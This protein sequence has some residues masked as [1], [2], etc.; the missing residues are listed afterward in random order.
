MNILIK[1]LLWNGIWFL[2]FGILNFILIPHGFT[3]RKKKFAVIIVSL[4]FSIIASLYF[5]LNLNILLPQ[6]TFIFLFTF[7]IL[8]FYFGSIA[9]CKNLFGKNKFHLNKKWD[10][11]LAIAIE[12]F[13]Q[14]TSPTGLSFR[15]TITAP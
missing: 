7:A 9:F 1:L 6:I 11:I 5:K 15:G 10:P 13:F 2:F 3:F 14:Q 4:F 8:A 12:V